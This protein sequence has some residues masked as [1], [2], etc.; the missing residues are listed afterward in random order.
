MLSRLTV[1]N[2][3]LLEVELRDEDRIV[4]RVNKELT[5]MKAQ[6]AI[7]GKVYEL[8]ELLS[9]QAAKS[10]I[11][12]PQGIYAMSGPAIAKRSEGP[13]L[14]L[15]DVAPTVLYLAGVPLSREL[16]GEVAWSAI[17]D[18]YRGN[19]AVTWVDSY[20]EYQVD[21]DR[22]SVDAE[23]MEKLRSLGYVR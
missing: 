23:T 16:E 1:D 5:S 8:A 14:Q 11:H 3:P 4:I 18:S 22:L 7:D 13:R 19:N 2:M 9:A 12:D 15:T 6:V 21:S 10:G 20:G 17:D